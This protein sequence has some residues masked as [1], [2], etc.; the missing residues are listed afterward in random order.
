MTEYFISDLHLGHSNILSM[1]TR[2][3]HFSCVDHMNEKIVQNIVDTVRDSDRLVL[4]GDIC[5]NKKSFEFL[6]LFPK[7]TILVGGNH[8]VSRAHYEAYRDAGWKI[9]GTMQHKNSILT[10]IPVHPR[11]LEERFKHNIHGHLHDNHVMTIA[12][13]HPN[14]RGFRVS[15]D[16]RYINVSC[17]VIEYVPKTY[18]QLLDHYSL[19]SE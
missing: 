3:D 8:D 4:L 15:R 17:E 2:K 5:W 6:K 10:H 14:L 16:I 11:Q 18:E 13:H 12:P 7:N 9:V 1:T 19:A